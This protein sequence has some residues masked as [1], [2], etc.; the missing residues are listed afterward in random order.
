MGYYT[1]YKLTVTNESSPEYRQLVEFLE[2]VKENKDDEETLDGM[3]IPVGYVYDF[4]LGDSEEC[5]WYDHEDDMKVFSRKFPT[6]L[7]KL[8]GKGEES[9][10]MWVK[11][12]RD[13]KM[14][15]C[16]A[17]ITFDDYDESKLQ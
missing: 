17:K 1:R 7:F 16:E 4:W 3:S 11:Y 9:G 5:K 14:Q 10:D 6:L 12:F 8:E 13:G 15:V 2:I